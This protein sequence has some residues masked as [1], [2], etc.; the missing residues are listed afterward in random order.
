MANKF[1]NVGLVPKSWIS[2]KM[3]GTS[4]KMAGTSFKMAGTSFKMAGLV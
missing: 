3:A 2:F 4:F 1:K